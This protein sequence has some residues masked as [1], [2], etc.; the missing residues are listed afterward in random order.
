MNGP[1]V[2]IPGSLV[3][4]LLIAIVGV[5]WVWFVGAVVLPRVDR[6]AKRRFGDERETSL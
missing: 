4:F 2:T 6:W 5:L 1:T 3:A